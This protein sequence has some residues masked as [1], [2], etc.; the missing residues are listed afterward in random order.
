MICYTYTMLNRDVTLER[1][2]KAGDL[3]ARIQ[4]GIA[5]SENGCWLWQRYRDSR[6]YGCTT[7][8]GYPVRCHT[9]TWFMKHGTIPE[10][11]RHLDH[12]C[13][14]PQCC[15]PA[16]L[17]D[18]THQENLSRAAMLKTHCPQGHPYDAE[19]TCWSGGCRFCK[20]CKRQKQNAI[21]D[22]QY[23]ERKSCGL[24]VKCGK[25]VAAEGKSMCLSCLTKHAARN[26]KKR[27]P[28][29]A[30]AEDLGHLFARRASP[31]S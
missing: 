12:L 16:H 1:L 13:N 30:S 17:R 15:N 29:E 11:G 6:G 21:N 5:V 27:S 10:Q 26:R 8:S 22:R 25:T 24:C 28:S 23:Q 2:R 9:V 14:T 3:S 19:N 31:S 18:C 4:D 20:T 7:V